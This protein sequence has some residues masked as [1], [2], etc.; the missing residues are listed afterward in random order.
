MVLSNGKCEWTFK[1]IW[2]FARK[3]RDA[4]LKKVLEGLGNPANSSTYFRCL[5]I[6][7]LVG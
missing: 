6:R 2:L 5:N 1:T 7:L 3:E 4:K